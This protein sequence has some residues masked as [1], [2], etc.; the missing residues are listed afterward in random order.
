MTLAECPDCDLRIGPNSPAACWVLRAVFSS[1]PC[2][3]SRPMS[4]PTSRRQFVG[5]STAL[6]GTAALASLFDAD[7]LAAQT[8]ER[9]LTHFAPTA[10][11]VV[12]LFQS[13]GPSHLDLLDEKTAEQLQTM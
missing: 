4:L 6:L 2:F 12:Y 3:E 1:T 10:K 11:R 5:R 13:G 7:G 9:L 8:P